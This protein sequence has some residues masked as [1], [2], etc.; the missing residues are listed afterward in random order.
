MP[1]PPA[2]I[3]KQLYRWYKKIEVR[4]HPLLYLF[5]EITRRC[6]LNCIHC[7]SDCSASVHTPEL[8]AESWIS[9]V[10]YVRDS[11]G[12]NVTFVIT[13]GEPLVHPELETI[14]AGIKALDMKWGMVTNGFALTEDR[15]KALLDRGLSSVTISLDGLKY[16][17]DKLR[18]REGAYEKAVN[19]MDRIGR[20]DIRFKDAVT[21]V[22]PDNI[23]ELDRIAEL[24]L[25]K[26]MTSWRL[27]RIFPL[28]RVK[29]NPE[30][31]LNYQDTMKV[32][33]WIRQNRANYKKRG[34]SVSYSC[35]G[36]MPHERDTGIRD[37]PFFCRAGI[38]IASILC[39]GTITGCSN[40]QPRFH[41][42][43]ILND[44]LL[45]LWQN[46]F[47]KFRDRSWAKS[48]ECGKCGHF[49]DCQGSSIHLWSD[50]SEAPAFCYAD[51]R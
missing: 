11:F 28:G 10:R 39:D 33:D 46:G 7:G 16:S 5:L 21:C 8:T 14:A 51:D 35:E 47:Q 50:G 26:G 2:F 45:T 9:I 12:K 30:L 48:G 40:N 42:G 6:N 17:H 32:L 4:E 38:N 49:R 22:Y 23:H 27:F 18:N 20:S 25:D 29:Q 19:A 3:A 31:L 44:D 15:W 41:E 13:G 36:W 37:L 34:L 1:R 24:L 43:N